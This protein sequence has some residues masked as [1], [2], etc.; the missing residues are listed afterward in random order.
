YSGGQ[1]HVHCNIS[2]NLVSSNV[3]GTS[4]EGAAGPPPELPQWSAE[5]KPLGV[6]TV[7]YTDTKTYS[8]MNIGASYYY[9]LSFQA[10][11]RNEAYE[12]FEAGTTNYVGYI[13]RYGKKY[14]NY[15]G[16]VEF[17]FGGGGP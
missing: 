17:G 12:K 16:K 9:E 4:D 5:C 1:K 11:S 15:T 7:P 13:D 3:T 6:Q 8:T 14:N 2:W 10:V